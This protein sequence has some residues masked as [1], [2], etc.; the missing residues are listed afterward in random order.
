MNRNRL[1]YEKRVNRVVDYIGAE[2]FAISE[3]KAFLIVF[4]MACGYLRE[5][6][7]DND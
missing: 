6:A 2:P 5:P 7:R 1:E 3:Q 4:S